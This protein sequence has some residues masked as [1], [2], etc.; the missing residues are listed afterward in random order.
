MGNDSKIMEQE[1]LNDHKDEEEKEREKE[2]T[3][4][5]TKEEKPKR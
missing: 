1:E 5:E 4:E 3:K 2:D